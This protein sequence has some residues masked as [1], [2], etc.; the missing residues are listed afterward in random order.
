MK[1]STAQKSILSKLGTNAALEALRLNEEQGEGPAMIAR[2]F[3]ITIPQA[4]ALI[5][6]GRKIKA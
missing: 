6:A 5:N 2:E 3:D 1:L 4:N